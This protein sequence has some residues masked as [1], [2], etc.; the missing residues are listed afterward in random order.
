M[1]EVCTHILSRVPFL[2]KAFE[3]QPAYGLFGMQDNTFGSVRLKPKTGGFREVQVRNAQA[4]YYLADRIIVLWE[5][6]FD[7]RFRRNPLAEDQNMQQLWSAFE[8]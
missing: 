6:F 5:C 1:V 3:G 7:D 4:W 8:S 2:A